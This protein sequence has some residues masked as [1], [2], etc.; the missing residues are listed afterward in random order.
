MAQAGVAPRDPMAS[1]IAAVLPISEAAVSALPAARV[2]A[3]DQRPRAS[4]VAAGAHHPEHREVQRRKVGKRKRRRRKAAPQRRSRTSFRCA[5]PD[6]QTL[7]CSGS[8][9]FF[10]CQRAEGGLCPHDVEELTYPTPFALRRCRALTANNNALTKLAPSPPY[11]YQTD[12]KVSPQ[13]MVC[14][15]M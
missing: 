9:V 1:R 5:R 15:S 7:G 11:L 4:S 3:V 12:I 2:A 13:C 6:L 14:S 8:G 10:Y